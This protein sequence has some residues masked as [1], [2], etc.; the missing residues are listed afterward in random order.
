MRDWAGRKPNMWTISV[1][2]T[3]SRDVDFSAFSA[4]HVFEITVLPAEDVE[5]LKG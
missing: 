4:Q 2:W 3:G 1:V 5:G